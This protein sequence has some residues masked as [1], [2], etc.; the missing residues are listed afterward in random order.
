MAQYMAKGIRHAAANNKGVA[1]FKQIFQNRY[2]G[3]NLGP[4]NNSNTRM[5][6]AVEHLTKKL[7]FFG[8]QKARAGRQAMSHTFGGGMGPVSGTKGIVDV[9]VGQ[10]RQFLGKI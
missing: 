3:R 8:H 9:E 7:A 1:D 5:F 2:F 10:G 4:A 6:G